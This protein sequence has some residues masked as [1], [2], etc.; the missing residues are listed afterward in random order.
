MFHFRDDT[1]IVL[2]SHVGWLWLAIFVLV[3]I[4]IASE[5]TKKDLQKKLE[6]SNYE[7]QNGVKVLFALECFVPSINPPISQ[8]SL[9]KLEECRF[10]V[11]MRVRGYP[12]FPI[13]D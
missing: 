9:V 11:S 5:G 1:H 12:N 13:F 3:V 6:A 8:P 7:K 4:A 2:S 10:F